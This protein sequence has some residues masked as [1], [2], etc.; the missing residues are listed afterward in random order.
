V[1]FAEEHK[2]QMAADIFMFGPWRYFCKKY[3]AEN[4]V[5][6]VHCPMGRDL[7][8][9]LPAAK[10]TVNAP[11]LCHSGVK[12]TWSGAANKKILTRRSFTKSCGQDF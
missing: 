6:P 5:G 11:N 10:G 4:E 9:Y 7:V 2:A 3:N 12:V 8:K 1:H